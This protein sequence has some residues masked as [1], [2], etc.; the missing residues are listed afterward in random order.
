VRRLGAQFNAL[1][2]GASGRGA[3]RLPAISKPA[4]AYRSTPS[5]DHAIGRAGKLQAALKCRSCKKGLKK[6]SEPW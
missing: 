6:I 1:R 4:R 5:A 2:L 3:V